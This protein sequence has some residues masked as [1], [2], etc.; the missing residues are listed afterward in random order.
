MLAEEEALGPAGTA[1]TGSLPFTPRA[2]KVL[3]LSLREASQLGHNY[4]GTEHMLL[5]LVREGD[6]VAVQVLVSLGTDLSRVRQRVIQLLSGY[7]G[8]DPANQTTSGGRVS[9]HER[10]PG[11]S[12]ARAGT[13]W[14]A[15]VVRSGRG[16]VDFAEAHQTL[17]ELAATL[18]VK[19]LDAS[20]ITVSSVETDEGPG[21]RLLLRHRFD[22]PP[23][24]GGDKEQAEG[25]EPVA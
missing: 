10:E 9:R 19:V 20:R 1:P 17:A 16:P 12:P 15:Q 2:K 13:E 25:G 5:G 18:G 23:S 7:Q 8:K 14:T 24:T 4:I 11:S 3:E 21:L 22:D 6:S